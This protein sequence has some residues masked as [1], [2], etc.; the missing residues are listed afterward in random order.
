[1]CGKCE[2]ECEICRY[3]GEPECEICRRKNHPNHPRAAMFVARIFGIM[4]C[5]SILAAYSLAFNESPMTIPLLF[6]FLLGG[7]VV[8]LFPLFKKE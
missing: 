2:P 5:M 4:F 8:V 6:L 1:M 7:M 3:E